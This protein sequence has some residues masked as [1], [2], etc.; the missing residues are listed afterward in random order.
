MS[1]SGMGWLFSIS[2][3]GQRVFFRNKREKLMMI[4]RSITGL[5]L[6]VMIWTILAFGSCSLA[7]EELKFNRSGCKPWL[8][9]LAPNSEGL[10]NTMNA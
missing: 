8:F 10:K 9:P 6:L 4:F 3:R 7:S 5:S 2:A 1:G